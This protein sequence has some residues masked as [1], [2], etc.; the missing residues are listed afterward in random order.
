MTVCLAGAVPKA[1]PLAIVGLATRFPQDAS[2]TERLW[3][4]LLAKKCA[5][6]PIPE[7]RIGP[8]HYHP[9]PEHGGT[10]AAQGGHFLAEDPAYFDSSFFGITKGEAM[11]LDPQQRVVL[12]N[13]YHALENSGLTLEQVAG[14]NT[15]VYVSGFNHDHLAILNSDPETT[16]RHRVTGLTNS[17]HS[18]RVS[19]FFDLKGPS[20][21]VDTACSS[22]MAAL[23][24]GS[25]SLRTK[26][27]DMAIITGVTILNY[28]GDINGMS[29]QGFLSPDGRCFSF[30]HRAN[31]FA[32]GEGVGTVIVKRLSDALRDGDTI[33]AV[34]R[35]TGVNQDGRT[36]GLTLPSSDAQE[37]L[38]KTTYASAGLNFDDTT[39]V[40]A[41][42]T[43]TRQGDAIEARGVAQAFK[44]R[45]KDK[46]LYLGSVKASVGHLEGAA[47]V[48]GIIKSVLAL[49]NGIIPPQANFER[50][51]P[52]IPFQKWNLSIAN[53][54]VPWPTE[55]LRRVSINSFG[56]GG[57]N[58]HAILDDA[59]NY[60]QE[61]GLTGNHRTTIRAPSREELDALTHAAQ[62]PASSNLL[63]EPPLLNG[64]GSAVEENGTSTSPTQ[65][66]HSEV[67]NG[68]NGCHSQ[69]SWE[70]VE[71]IPAPPQLIGLSAFDEA[72]ISRNA[73]AQVAFLESRSTHPSTFLQDYSYT[74]NRRSQFSWRS[75]LLAG[76]T[77]E[78][79]AALPNA[80]S[81][82]LRAR[83][84]ISIA[85]VFTGQGAQYATMSRELFFYPVF[86]R[87]M[88]EASQF[89]TSLGSTWSLLDE[90]SRTPQQSNVNEPW[91]SQPA[92]TAVQVALVDLLRSWGVKPSRVVGHSSGEIAAA[93]AA[94]KLSRESAWRVAYYRGIVSAKQSE[95]SGAMLAVGLSQDEAQPYVDD[96]AAKGT[97]VVACSNSPRNCTI[98]GDE[99]LIS[100]LHDILHAKQIF[101]RK[102]P[103]GKAYH[104]P[105]M[106]HI[107]AEYGALLD[108]LS[109][110]PS[111][112]PNTVL[113]VSTVTGTF[114]TD[115]VLNAEYWVKNLVSQVRFS[116]GM[117]ATCFRPAQSG[118]ISLRVD[119]QGGNHFADV[120]LE[121]GSHGALQ[122]AIKDILA[123]QPSG[124]GITSFPV[125]NRSKPGPDTLLTALGHIWCRGYPIS[126][127]K[128]NESSQ[129]ESLSR[130]HALLTDVPSYAFNHSQLLWYESRLS[131]NYRLRKAPRHDLF[132]APV[133][134]W[135]K[136]SP[137][138]R[139]IFRISEQ[140]WLRDHVV[141]N[142]YVYPGVGY[143][144]MAI[145]AIQQIADEGMTINSFRLRDISIKRAMI[146]PDNKEG[147]E[148]VISMHR[149]DESSLSVSKAWR[150]FQISS[151]NPAGDDWI[152]HCTG[153]IAVEY[154][155]ADGPVDGGREAREESAMKHRELQE[156]E[157][158]CQATFD[159]F[160]AYENMATV[161]LQF[162]PLFRNG[163]DVSGT[164]NKGGAVLGRVTVP[165]IAASMPKQHA[166]PH[167]I[168]PAT[169]DSMIHFALAAIMDLFGATSL[170]N[171][172]VPTF[173]KDVWVSAELSPQP[174]H[175]YKVHGRT[176]RVAFE[177]YD[178]DVL[179]WDEATGDA[180][181][182]VT[183]IRATP[184]DSADQRT[185]T[186]RELCHEVKWPVYLE[187]ISQA[188]LVVEDGPVRS[189]S[190]TAEWVQR[191][192]L[193]TLCLVHDALDTYRK[194]PGTPQG[195]LQNYLKWLEQLEL[196]TSED[197]ISSVSRS[198]FEAIRYND[199]A[200]VELYKQIQEYKAEG[201]LAYRMGSNIFSVLRG[202][203]DPLH[204]MFGQDNILD[205]V[206][207]DL[208]RLGN[209]PELLA[210]YLQILGENRTNLR[211][212]EV[213]AGTGSSTE[214]IIR[215]LAPVSDDGKLLQSSVLQ[216]TYTDISSAFFEKA[217][218]KFKLWQSLFEYKVLH[219]EKDVESQGFE[220]EMYDIVVAQNVI[221]A[222]EDLHAT[223][224]NL[225]KLLKPGGRILIQE[226]MRQ[227]YFWSALAFGQLSGWWLSKEEMR[228]WCP[229]ASKDQWATLLKE[230]GFDGVEL[231]LKDA[232][233]SVTH[234][235]SILVSRAVEQN[236]V[237][238]VSREK[239]I[240]VA[241]EV[242]GS[243][244]VI[245]L[246]QK[247]K[248]SL[249]SRNVSIMT[250]QQLKDEDLNQTLCVSL[251]ELENPV[252]SILTPEDYE[253]VRKMLTECQALLWITGDMMEN[254]QYGMALG[255]IRT[256][257]W[258]RD[259]DDANLVTL[260]VASPR[261]DTE[262]LIQLVCKLS[263]LQFSN[264]V[265]KDEMQGEYILK[266][267]TF[268]TSRLKP[269]FGGNHF[270]ASQFSTPQP[271]PTAWKDAG[272]PVKLV[273]ASPG[274]L[275]R[276]QWV[277]DP[278][279]NTPLDPT[280]VEIEIK[281]MGLNFRD[282][283]IAM[284]EHMA[285]SIGCEA[286]GV[287]S[288]VGS[289]VTD[290]VV[291]DRVTYITGLDHVGC[292]HT[293]GRVDQ[294]VVTK[295]PE[296][297]SYED[298]AGL[299][300]VYVTVL[301]GLRDVARLAK[302]EKVLIHA[303][304]GGVGQA[305]INYAKSV[306]AEIFA[307]CSTAEKRDLLV[308][309]CGI[310]EDHIFSSRDLTFA[311]GIRRM[312]G[313][314]GVDVVLNSLAGDALRCSWELLAPFGRFIE[315]GKKDIQAN[316]K[317][318]LRPLLM[319][320]SMTCVDLVTM[321]NH[322]PHLIKQGLDDTIRL[323]S[324]GIVKPAKPT[325]VSPLSKLVEGFQTLQSGRG[326]GKMVFVPNSD[327]VVPIVPEQQAPFTFRPD[328]TYVLSGGLGGLG[329]SIARW[330]VGRGTRNLL[331]LSRSGNITPAVAEMEKHLAEQGC[332]IRIAKCDVADATEL[333]KVL[334]ECKS[335]LPPIKGVIQGA[336]Q[337]SD[338]IFEN[339]TYDSYMAAVKPK[340]LGSWNLH[341]HLPTDLDHFVLLS[342][343]T[344]ILGNR[345]QANYAAGNTY[346]DALA[347]HR[348]A[349]GLTATSID[350]GAILSVGYV[351]ENS[352][353]VAINKG[354]SV[355]L[356]QIR[357]EELHAILEY[358]IDA[359]QQPPT[360]IVTGLANRDKY[361]TKGMPT[362]SFMKFP[363][364]AHVNSESLIGSAVSESTEVPVE[365]L[366]AASK[367]LDEAADIITTA[368]K[369]K[370]ASLLSVAV[371]DI[372][373]DKS[374][375]ANGIDSLVAIE[376]RT[377]LARE[378]KADVPMLD[379]MGTSTIKVLCRK[380]AMLSRAVDVK[381]D[382]KVVE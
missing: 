194:L 305:A 182:S 330:M 125:L 351:A 353:R 291:G 118:Q 234:T 316:S 268:L 248:D 65:N 45:R 138:W 91:L 358:A 371:A 10:H 127:Q 131:R 172:A 214:A 186:S 92:C 52:K 112:Q 46:P 283:M 37:R 273:S 350:V 25:Q 153:Y 253:G 161:G 357:E 298:A 230:A 38:I 250:V 204:L 381:Q 103:I 199:A 318:E 205:E 73:E 323:W 166:S 168:H 296:G 240:I 282:L 56:V 245:G 114:V 213:G 322:R 5:H 104:S 189:D 227:D 146:V 149:V 333:Q 334:E 156:A 55:G 51:N 226:G 252:L 208:V 126:I 241:S 320:T 84:P 285:Y 262:D 225:R 145:E 257:R 13:V 345:G 53:E 342:S 346:Q 47:G 247:L 380:I 95:R 101:V 155:M 44:S 137:Q 1:E 243:D 31:G 105:H 288:R 96:L 232:Q 130:P 365:A 344:G 8:G 89:F 244:L 184:L 267:G 169:F 119:T 49:E 216:Y 328:A 215:H 151:Y 246:Q 359:R 363:L 207:A 64:N 304:A 58:A 142:S 260:S 88:E 196:W 77:S 29:H 239:L 292:F 33:R 174:G 141:T 203:T 218:E 2:T 167:L 68:L 140:P 27:S 301:Y 60:L 139:N 134:D 180:R 81:K 163:S 108:G 372:D 179:V 338:S 275:D 341:A 209:L 157:R 294:S 369:G 39:L 382:D 356:E 57:T 144:I 321:M 165:D 18:N 148:V 312:T 206:Y 377:F 11:S 150:R 325:T 54:A 376:F 340:V 78:L 83:G 355:E 185:S 123:T 193:A 279:Y 231:E 249:R 181:I 69:R 290:V 26:E 28:P 287:I 266:A 310:P 324:E 128:I 286:S 16:L 259:L 347:A 191:L 14:S 12:E 264:T 195:H 24:L 97:L 329:R 276:L 86:R 366:L 133:P 152:E 223:L 154:A 80:H 176:E 300:A 370:L 277:T 102:L 23:H 30:D 280:H 190:L 116:D 110:D 237:L 293:F 198:D 177:K 42:G 115:E 59:Y 113:M 339:M 254:P 272:R 222:T 94:G 197:K 303:A 362:P 373:E 171:P 187:T 85:Y 111:I 352:S 337:L 378:V 100:E 36:P 233:D 336:M 4:F 348:H 17:M 120:V 269:S 201:R 160:R 367:T 41:H 32:R 75:F 319:G 349:Q 90:L 3:Q 295:I 379:V 136:E 327:D 311:K 270:L 263:A 164:G 62:A 309:E 200:K 212:L 258:E 35:G 211:V 251:L 317:I 178:N 219:A 308:Q 202:E 307:T 93:Y 135:N 221:H 332:K 256:V 122:S 375:S 255:L 261:P 188:D 217:R 67:E 22:S 274:Q 314:Y 192:Q 129:L 159:M 360:Q 170:E 306:G 6:T 297:L 281:A 315:I 98:S 158:R 361:R 61:Q 173:I 66:G 229:F 20:V 19:W 50:A 236:A 76:N 79:L 331:F 299:P 364:F 40:E 109:P 235:Q 74:M 34:A 242:S 7:D 368:V 265:S 224:S 82:V 284:G 72:G 354:V 326:T 228:R 63:S 278:V 132:G 87:S 107:A 124:T 374:I 121:L 71:Q 343:A 238:D 289:Q 210:K 147:L 313:G 220:A 271:V 9:D 117:T 99:N 302:G 21:T 106:N 48:A 70:L 43:G 143:L 335:S 175:K 162:G 15:S 183:G